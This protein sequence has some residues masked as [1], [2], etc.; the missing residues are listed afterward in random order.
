MW[1]FRRFS[2][3]LCCGQGFVIEKEGNVLRFACFS[4]AVAAYCDFKCCFVFRLPGLCIRLGLGL[5]FF[6]LIRIFLSSLVI[7][8]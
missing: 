8:P 4:V 2:R 1:P 7:L 6:A 3:V 5:S